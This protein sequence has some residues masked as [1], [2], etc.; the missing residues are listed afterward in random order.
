MLIARALAAG[1][2]IL[3]LDD[4]SS[5]LDYRTDAQLRRGIREHFQDTTLVIVAQ[6][7][8]SIRNVDHIL[9]MEDGVPIGYGS[10]EELMERC[11]VY[12]ETSVNQGE[13]NF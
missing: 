1:P 7:V 10:H 2:E 13:K 12:R 6:R 3:I 11:A 8:S 9:V 5:A 4:S